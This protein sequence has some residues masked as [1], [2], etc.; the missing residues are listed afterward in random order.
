MDPLEMIKQSWAGDCIFDEDKL[1][2]ESL[3]IPSLHAKYQDFWS[4]YSLILEDNK[5]KLSILKRDKYLFYTGKA[6]AEVYKEHPFDLKVLKNDLNTF[7]EADADIQTQQLKIAYFETVINYLEGVLKQ[8]NNRTY[9]IKNA[10]EH[11]RFE[12]GF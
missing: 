2:S 7:M 5:K 11:R 6:D 12:A 8:I 4:K 1:D 3:K 9:H 10:L